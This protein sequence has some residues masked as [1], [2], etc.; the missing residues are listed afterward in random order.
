MK[1][2]WSSQGVAGVLVALLSLI[3]GGCGSSPPQG[4]GVRAWKR[5]EVGP[6]G[7]VTGFTGR[8]LTLPEVDR[9]FR[10]EV[11]VS[12]IDPALLVEEEEMRAWMESR[13]EDYAVVNRL[14]LARLKARLE[15][16]RAA[17]AP[18]PGTE[19]EIRELEA[20]LRLL[21][22][23]PADPG[24]V[25]DVVGLEVGGDVR[26]HVDLDGDGRLE[27]PLPTLPLSTSGPPPHPTSGR[28]QDMEL[29]E[30]PKNPATWSES[31]TDTEFEARYRELV[32]ERGPEDL[33]LLRGRLEWL[34]R[35]RRKLHLGSVI[36]AAD[37]IL[38]LTRGKPDVLELHID[39]LYRKGRA[40]AYQELPD[41]LAHTPIPDPRSHQAEF[42]KTFE[43]LSSL[44]DTTDREYFL[45]HVRHL[46]RQGHYG[47]AMELLREHLENSSGSRPAPYLYLKKIMDLTGLCRW[48]HRYR[49]EA[50]RLLHLHPEV[51]GRL[52]IPPPVR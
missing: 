1:N 37:S 17:S 46:R 41:V 48:P 25:A 22:E 7:V 14:L 38:T 30:D 2:R 42:E 21:S 27:L 8:T 43:E 20:R 40:L 36:E 12:W 49:R 6:D 32:V 5:V 35:V 10:G 52:A 33:E 51:E 50:E 11:R 16:A 29:E 45:L 28:S 34:D 13:A 4:E 31:L 15:R 26:Y 44:V 24:P 47:L 39:T 19:I 3:G 9:E 23:P 18:G